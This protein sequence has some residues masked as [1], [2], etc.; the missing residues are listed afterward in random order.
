MQDFEQKKKKKENARLLFLCI[1]KML[2]ETRGEKPNN[3]PE[4]FDE[5]ETKK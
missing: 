2:P 3:Q 1:K 4:D 5:K